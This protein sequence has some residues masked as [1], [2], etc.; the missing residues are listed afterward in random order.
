MKPQHV[1]LLSLQRKETCGKVLPKMTMCFWPYSD[2][3]NY[4]LPHAWTK[5]KC[6]ALV[7]KKMTVVMLQTRIYVLSEIAHSSFFKDKYCLLH[8]WPRMQPLWW[9]RRCIQIQRGILKLKKSQVWLNLPGKSEINFELH[10]GFVK[11]ILK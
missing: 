7:N 1:H 4:G 5:Q 6:S 2:T 11:C 8:I 3:K 10:E 9:I